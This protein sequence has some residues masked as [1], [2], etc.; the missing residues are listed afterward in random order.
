MLDAASNMDDELD[1]LQSCTKKILRARK[2]P[3]KLQR[4]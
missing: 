1:N 4:Q 2:K 3:I